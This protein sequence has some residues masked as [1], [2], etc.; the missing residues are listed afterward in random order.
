MRKINYGAYC[1]EN[2]FTQ[3]QRV[4]FLEGVQLL[5]QHLTERGRLL[6]RSF[7]DT[8]PRMFGKVIMVTGGVDGEHGEQSLHWVGLALDF[9]F[10]D[11]RRGAIWVP[12]PEPTNE[13]EHEAIRTIQR[14]LAARWAARAVRYSDFKVQ[15][16]VEARHI[17]GEYDVKGAR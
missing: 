2:S 3:P 16:I 6:F 10:I 13:E 14:D 12:G 7:V 9:R 11:Y 5:P 15:G 1:D 17:H 8:A 4:E